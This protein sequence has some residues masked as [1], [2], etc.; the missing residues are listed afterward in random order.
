MTYDFQKFNAFDLKKAALSVSNYRPPR[1]PSTPRFTNKFWEEVKLDD[2]KQPI[3]L[4]AGEFVSLISN[5]PA[6]WKEYLLHKTLYIK[7]QQQKD[8][9]CSAGHD[10]Y[11]K[12]PC[13]GCYYWETGPKKE[14]PWYPKV[15]IK[16]NALSLSQY[17]DNIP[18]IKSGQQV[19]KEDGKPVFIK[20]RCAGKACTLCPTYGKPGLSGRLMKLVLTGTH[21]NQL[22]SYNKKLLNLCA[23]CGK[24]IVL[25]D[26]SCAGCGDQLLNVAENRFSEEY[27]EQYASTPVQCHC[28]HT[29]IPQEG[30][31]CGYDEEGMTKEV[32]DCP[33]E[34]P[35]R[36][37]IF[38]TVIPLTKEGEK[39]QSKLDFGE[40]KSIVEKSKIKYNHPS[41]LSINEILQNAITANNGKLFDLDE[42]T[43][44]LSTEEQAAHLNVENP[45]ANLQGGVM[46]LPAN[47]PVQQI[48]PMAHA[49]TVPLGGFPVNF[50]NIK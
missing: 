34:Y 7:G 13:V 30:L 35:V 10:P 2:V 38:N 41:K 44:I 39:T 16:F 19:K 11:N 26:F 18:Y 22:M 49:G 14:N 43:R 15:T 27:L 31:D 36:M 48:P 8:I 24:T 6:P 42:E 23:G 5:T 4:L 37:N 45:Y 47:V 12:Q 40:K 17:H 20:E 33:L 1:A 50:G 21:F 25:N 46:G 29:G 28:G 32:E 3:L 9:V